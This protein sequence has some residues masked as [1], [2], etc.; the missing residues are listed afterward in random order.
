MTKTYVRSWIGIMAVSFWASCAM[1]SA[2]GASERSA[3]SE[4][5]SAASR[6]AAFVA[7]GDGYRADSASHLVDVLAGDVV[8]VPKALAS[9]EGAPLTSSTAGLGTVSLATTAVYRGATGLDLTVLESGLSSPDV[10]ETVRADFIE[11]LRN[12]EEG[13]EQSW[14]FAQAPGTSGNL[15]VE[16]TPSSVTYSTS[17]AAGLLFTSSTLQMSYGHGTW[18]DADGD[19]WAIPAAYTSGHIQLTVP[20]AV[21]AASAFPAVL[22]PQIIV[23]PIGGQPGFAGGGSLR[24]TT[25]N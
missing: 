23:S 16:V 12:T 17:T 22:D 3:Q 6:A 5:S 8:L 13:A 9:S 14:R 19:R 20:A 24:P 21:L 25:G 18:I 2:G 1:D 4:T 7:H 15:V 10:V 11:L